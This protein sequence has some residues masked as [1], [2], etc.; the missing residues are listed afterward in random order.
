MD[1]VRGLYYRIS[2]FLDEKV[3][4]S[5]NEAYLQHPAQLP[6]AD[7]AASVSNGNSRGGDLSNPTYDLIH[8]S[9]HASHVTAVSVAP[10]YEVLEQSHVSTDNAAQ[11]YEMQEANVVGGPTTSQDYEV[12]V[13]NRREDAPYSHLIHK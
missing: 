9:P 12:P 4:L 5:Q 10:Q 1:S 3:Y 7:N 13:T 6:S 8:D 2:Q 11:H